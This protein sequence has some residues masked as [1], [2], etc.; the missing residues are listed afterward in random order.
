MAIDDIGKGELQL[1]TLSCLYLAIK[2][3]EAS[4]IRICGAKSTMESLLRL[5]RARFSV[6]QMMRMEYDV[7]QRLQWRMHPPTPQA[8]AEYFAPILYPS[9][10]RLLRDQALYLI[11]LAA[12]DYYF[13]EY[14]PSEI[15]LA[16]SLNASQAVYPEGLARS[17]HHRVFDD[18]VDPNDPRVLQCQNRLTLL[19]QESEASMVCG[20]QN[21][22]R[23]SSPVSVASSFR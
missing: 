18:L 12:L 21:R 5:A 8:F 23:V 22:C 14:K 15:A 16:A 20:E 10:P 19:L 13:V 7:L 1:L 2:L 6:D 3:N 17:M 11:E 9:N 4:A